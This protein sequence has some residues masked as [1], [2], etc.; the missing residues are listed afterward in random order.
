MVDS[1]I[2]FIFVKNKKMKLQKAL[3]LKKKL[4][5]EI[6]KLQDQIRQ[7][8]S[9]A[10]GSMDAINYNVPEL[11]SKLARKTEELIDLKMRIYEGNKPIQGV[12][13]DIAETKGSISF[14]Q[15]LSCYE[16]EQTVGYGLRETLPKIF[17][18]QITE[19]TKD[20]MIEKLQ[21]RLDE[22]Q[23]KVDAFNYTTDI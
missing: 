12:I 13:F 9:Y 20:A 10:E 14:W 3:K 22:L 17:K 2:R 5:G 11:L 19:P 16:G 18:A 21:E 15:G 8:N 4:A 1:D 7:K 6:S 23:E